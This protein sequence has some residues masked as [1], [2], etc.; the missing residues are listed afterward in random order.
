MI[1]LSNVVVK[2]CFIAAFCCYPPVLMLFY[3]TNYFR[4]TAV[5]VYRSGCYRRFVVFCDNRSKTDAK[6]E[7]W[8]CTGLAAVVVSIAIIAGGLLMILSCR[9]SQSKKY[10]TLPLKE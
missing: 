9:V 10:I 8:A 7:L 6:P 3:E 5:H 4:K 2:G 1:F